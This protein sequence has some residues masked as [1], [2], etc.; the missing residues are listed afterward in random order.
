MNLRDYQNEIARDDNPLNE[1]PLNE[2]MSDARRLAGI[3]RYVTRR[4]LKLGYSLEELASLD[5]E[6]R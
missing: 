5:M 1:H 3:L 2:V 6:K 4:A